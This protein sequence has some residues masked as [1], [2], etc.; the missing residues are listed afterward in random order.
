MTRSRKDFLSDMEYIDGITIIDTS[1]NILF[2]VKFNPRFHPE[3]IH[4]DAIIG[5]K[6]YEVFQGITKEN[7]T[8][9]KAMELGKPIHK[10]R[11]S[12]QDIHGAIIET[13]NTSLP[14]KGNGTILGAIELSKDITRYKHR[15]NQDIEMDTLLF[16]HRNFFKEQFLPDKARYVL[17]DIISK[18]PKIKEIKY[19]IQRIADGTSP[20][21]IYGETGTGKELFAH[22]IH[23]SG[24]RSQGPFIAQNCAA[25][26]ENLLES[27][28]FGTTKGS[29]TGA[30][31]NMG[32]FELAEGGTLFLDEINSMPLNL[33]AKLLRVLQDGYIRRL[34]DIKE[35]KVNVRV[36]SASNLS[37][38]KCLQENQL[39][40][41]I[42][43]RLSVLAIH[44]PPLRER[45]EDIELL[46]NY[47]INKY[48]N[49]IHR[50]IQNVS[51]EVYQFFLD[52]HWPGNVRELEHLIE[53]AMNMLDPSE[54]TIEL[55]HIEQKIVEIRE[56]DSDAP[57]N[58]QPL[59]DAIAEVEKKLIQQAIHTTRGNVSEASRL[60]K[61]PRQ[62]LQRKIN[63]YG[64]F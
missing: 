17:D 48:N 37:P 13:T 27:I 11:Q 47:F 15:L 57:V 38:K 1:G 45:K 54:D 18:N 8:L 56:E 42:Y 55:E 44:V 33:Q 19:Y 2:S 22:A 10:K 51:K 12:F 29:F 9:I 58:I 24:K 50:K 53:Y 49:S 28:L 32:L 3:I 34:G 61:I 26:P 39:R 5:K 23:N 62:T 46:L 63:L 30:C 36:I 60:L 52:Y 4:E 59:K 40:Q 6:L 31:D 64:P 21:F 41:D 35:R 43:Y 16:T 25:I 7:S 20:V 14:I